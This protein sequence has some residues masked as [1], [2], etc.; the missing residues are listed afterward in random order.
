LIVDLASVVLGWDRI[1]G[2][3]EHLLLKV[4]ELAS[5]GAVRTGEILSWR[6]APDMFPL[7]DQLRFVANLV[8]QW[9]ARASG[10]K[11]PEELSGEFDIAELRS[12]L[13]G[14]RQYLSGLS[15]ARFSGRDSIE[16]TVSLGSIEPTMPIGRWVIGFATTNI[17]FHL[18]TAYAILRSNGVELGKRDLFAGGL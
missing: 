8:Q 2:S 11:V 5:G 18:S 15:P 14:A 17:L 9:A 1:L 10:E 4:E 7:R 12:G 3:A 16:L 13:A 6:L